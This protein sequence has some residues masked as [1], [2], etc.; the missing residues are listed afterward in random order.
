[1]PRDRDQAFYTHNSFLIDRMLIAEDLNFMQNFNDDTKN[2]IILNYEERNMDRFFANE[3]TLRDWLNAADTLQQ[4]LTDDVIEESVHELPPEIF[5]ISGKELMKKLESRRAHL[6]K[7]VT[8][9]Y[10]FLAK[11]V[12]ITGSNKNEYFEVDGS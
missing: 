9:Y 3:M 12:D 7:Y 4:A 2:I 1:M 10:R 11:Q 6:E 5:A 8:E